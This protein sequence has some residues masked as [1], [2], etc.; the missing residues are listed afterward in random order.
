MLG[1]RKSRP[2]SLKSPELF[3][4]FNHLHHAWVTA[5]KTANSNQPFTWSPSLVLR[6][7]YDYDARNADAARQ[8]DSRSA[9]VEQTHQPNDLFATVRGDLSSA[10]CSGVNCCWTSSPCLLRLEYPPAFTDV[11]FSDFVL[12]GRVS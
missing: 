11:A 5:Q 7:L 3:I 10:C 4:L 12:V 6:S 8:S 1:F 2:R 9:V